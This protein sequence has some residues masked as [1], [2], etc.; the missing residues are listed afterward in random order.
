MDGGLSGPSSFFRGVTA[1]EALC[2]LPVKA[3]IRRAL[4]A[5]FGTRKEIRDKRSFIGV[6]A[7]LAN[8]VPVGWARFRSS[9]LG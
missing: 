9:C 8:I 7:S 6:E 5:L 1:L 3:L 4:R 2:P